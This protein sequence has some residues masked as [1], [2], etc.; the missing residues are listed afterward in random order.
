MLKE[1]TSIWRFGPCLLNCRSYAELGDCTCNVTN[2]SPD[3]PRGSVEACPRPGTRNRSP[4]S[5][6]AGI[7][8]VV[9][10]RSSV[11]ELFN[12]MKLSRIQLTYSTLSTTRYTHIFFCNK[13]TAAPTCITRDYQPETSSLHH[14][15][16]GSTTSRASP[17]LR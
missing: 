5:T 7:F 8:M 17:H 15:L 6:P 13:A 12:L 16:P 10:F 11:Y 14:L 2:K 9:S 4:E 1:H 3:R